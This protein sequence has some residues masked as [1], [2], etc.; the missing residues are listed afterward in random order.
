M[1]LEG[2]FIIK[3]KETMTQNK[4]KERDYWKTYK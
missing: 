4:I 2:T 3:K 1:L